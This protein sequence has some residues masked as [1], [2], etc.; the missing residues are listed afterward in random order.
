MN[1]YLHIFYKTDYNYNDYL[2]IS[3]I[4]DI[5]KDLGL[6]VIKKRIFVRKEEEIKE[7]PSLCEFIYESNNDC[8]SL[9]MD[10]EFGIMTRI[11]VSVTT[12][13]DVMLGY[14]EYF[15]FGCQKY[16]PYVDFS[17][18]FESYKDNT[19]AKRPFD[20]HFKKSLRYEKGIFY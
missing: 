3:D 12:K 13:M 10:E 6:P 11:D 4:E 1:Y 5:L 20:G 19:K 16:T 8:S 15:V 9:V 14:G 2:P 18:T 7:N 17:D